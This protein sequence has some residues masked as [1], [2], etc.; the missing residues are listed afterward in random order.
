M[1]NFACHCRKRWED[2]DKKMVSIPNTDIIL[3][4]T[5]MYSRCRSGGI[6]ILFV[7]NT[8][9]NDTSNASNQPLINNP[10]FTKRV[11]RNPATPNEIMTSNGREY[12]MA[13]AGNLKFVQGKGTMENTPIAI[14]MMTK[15]IAN[16]SK[17]E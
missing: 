17:L 8:N 11:E 12:T 3:K 1:R 2:F 9:T 10:F 7:S 4:G 13:T 14:N 15:D 6:V 16:F 5:M